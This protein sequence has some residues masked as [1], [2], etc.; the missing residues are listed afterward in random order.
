MAIQKVTT[1]SKWSLLELIH[2]N[3]INLTVKPGMTGRLR[4]IDGKSRNPTTGTIPNG[5]I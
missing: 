5:A 3:E 1:P 4:L 2:L